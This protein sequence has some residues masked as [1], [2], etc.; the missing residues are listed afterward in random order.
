M[1]RFEIKLHLNISFSWNENRLSIKS[2][3]NKIKTISLKEGGRIRGGGNNQN[4]KFF[5]K[6]FKNV[7]L[8]KIIIIFFLIFSIKDKVAEQI[9]LVILVA[10]VSYPP[11]SIFIYFKFTSYGWKAEPPLSPSLSIYPLTNCM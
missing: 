7:F 3:Y 4:S 9:M 1:I 11:P 10:F 8:S 6:H 2:V 5:V